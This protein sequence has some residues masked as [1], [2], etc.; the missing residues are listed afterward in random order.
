MGIAILSWLFAVPLLGV[1]TGMRA[2]TPMAVLCWFAY[3]GYLPVDGTWAFWTA[4]FAVVVAFTVLAVGEYVG[5]KLPRTPNRTSPAPL[6]ARLVFGGL[7][8][9]IAATAM[10]GPGVEG[11]VLGIVGAALGAFGGFMVRRDLVERLGCPD[12]P[13]AVVEDASAILCAVFAAH[14]VTS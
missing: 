8:G 2:M 4:R 14:V 7:V 9:S 11:V 1:A 12:W 5:D 3:L 13:V 6:L 10:E